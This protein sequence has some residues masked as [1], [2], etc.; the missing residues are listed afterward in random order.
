MF[1]LIQCSPRPGGHHET[2]LSR[3]GD[4]D[5]CQLVILPRVSAGRVLP[6]SSDVDL[7]NIS[8]VQPINAILGASRKVDD[9]AT[10]EASHMVIA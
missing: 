1:R 9:V 7:G 2:H 6:D 8:I 10:A 5:M 4:D 3:H